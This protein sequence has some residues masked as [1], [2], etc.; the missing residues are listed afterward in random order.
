MAVCSVT[1]SDLALTRQVLPLLADGLRVAL[2]G[3][4]SSFLAG[5][6]EIR[7]RVGRPLHLVGTAGEVF[8]SN[9]VVSAADFRSTVELITGSSLYALEEE[10]RNGYITLS[11]GHRVG[12]A[13]RA[14][15]E[16]GR[17]RTL[18]HL[19]GLVIR[20]SREFPGAGARV[21]EVI[22]PPGRERPCSA[23]V[24]SPPRAGKTT[25]LRDLARSMSLG[26]PGRPGLKV[27]I[28]DERSEIAGCFEG[29][30]Q[31]DVGPRTDVLD[32]CPKAAGMMMALRA[33]GPEVLVADEVGRPEDAESIREAV[34]AGVTVLCS[35]HGSSLDELRRRPAVREIIE[36]GAFGHYVFLGRRPLPG[37]VIAIL[38]GEGHPCSL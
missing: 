8:L 13:G 3:V 11:G 33:L 14:V 4:D 23:L 7:L 5:L 31:K 15:V 32:A 27:V 10:L 21:L 2:S 29:V 12:L 38:D 16:D 25:V 17:V 26:G 22:W 6:E 9:V 35:A 28:V 37:T 20:V 34:N 1:S 24:V 19:G 18:K 30:P 36:S